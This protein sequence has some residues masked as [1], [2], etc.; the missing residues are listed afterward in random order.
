M[1]YLS[2]YFYLLA[3]TRGVHVFKKPFL[4]HAEVNI[5]LF[6]LERGFI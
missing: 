2:A 3:T 6:S 5:T 4:K 1:Y